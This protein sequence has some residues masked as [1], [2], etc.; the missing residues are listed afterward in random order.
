M[1]AAE[2]MTRAVVTV[3]ENALLVDAVRLMLGQHISG[4]PVV[5]TAGRLAGILTEGDLLRRAETGTERRRPRWVEFL[6]SPGQQAEEYVRTHGRRV[7]QIMTRDVVS[8]AESTPLDEV[9]ETMERH[10]IRRVPVTGD[11]RLVGI[12]S[13]A[14]LLRA[15]LREMP[16]PDSDT[17]SDLTLRQAIEAELSAQPWSSR[18]N[19]TVVVVDGVANLEGVI[20]DERARAAMCVA[21]ENVP[22]VREVHDHLE[23]YDPNSGLIY[24]P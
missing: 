2:I 1:K 21:A 23:F 19:V 12:I 13:R 5:D 8:V 20:Y 18:S 7:G 17:H 10:R 9:V 14:D 6:R 11:G 16:A 3:P 4:L 24:G 15:L 22:G